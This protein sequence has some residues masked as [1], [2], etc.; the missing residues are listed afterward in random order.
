M[1]VITDEYYVQKSGTE[2]HN[3]EYV[4]TALINTATGSA[5][6]ETEEKSKCYQHRSRKAIA[7]PD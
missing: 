6:A 3:N 4:L 5:M 2:Y 1:D 7:I